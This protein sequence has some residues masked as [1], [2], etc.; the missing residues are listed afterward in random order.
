M[1]DYKSC[2][3]AYREIMFTLTGES[4]SI[5]PAMLAELD[6]IGQKPQTTLSDSVVLSPHQM[7]NKLTHTLKLAAEKI[8]GLLTSQLGRLKDMDDTSIR[9]R[10]GI[11]ALNDLGTLARLNRH[12]NEISG[13]LDRF[14][15]TLR[16]LGSSART[17]QDGSPLPISALNISERCLLR[18]KMCAVRAHPN[19]MQMPWELFEALVMS[20]NVAFPPDWREYA[21]PSE[22]RDYTDTPLYLGDAETIIYNCDGKKLIDVITMIIFER[23]SKVMITTAG[24]VGPNYELGLEALEALIALGPYAPEV[25]VVLSFNLYS[26]MNKNEYIN[27]KEKTLELLARSACT[28]APVNIR[29]KSDE[30]LTLTAFKPLQTRFELE[31]LVEEIAPIGAATD[32]FVFTPGDFPRMKSCPYIRARDAGIRPSFTV[33]PDGSVAISCGNFGAR[34]ANVGNVY[35]NCPKQI[36]ELENVLRK[37]LAGQLEQRSTDKYPCEVHRTLNVHLKAPR[38]KNPIIPVERRLAVIHR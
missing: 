21:F 37:I 22:S 30:N 2:H 19:D 34:G 31:C 15:N 29:Y 12:W 16:R 25:C 8:P 38:S 5:T 6:E 7:L 26:G 20:P 14:E 10:T 28:F 9:F 33:R 17:N 1:I 36:R 4:R 3:D 11:T 27:G 32:N 24:L 18:C 35:K 13:K 23:G